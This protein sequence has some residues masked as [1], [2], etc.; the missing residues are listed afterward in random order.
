MRSWRVHGTHDVHL[1]VLE[2]LVV[3]V[4]VDYVVRVVYPESETIANETARLD[5]ILYAYNFMILKKV[6]E[7]IR[8]SRGKGGWGRENF[9]SAV[10]FSVFDDECVNIVIYTLS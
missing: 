8:L 9:F 10:N 5:N 2:R 7:Q 4:H 6:S 3:F 1:I